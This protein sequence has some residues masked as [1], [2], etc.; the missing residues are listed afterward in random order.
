MNSMTWT[1]RALNGHPAKCDWEVLRYQEF[2]LVIAS[3]RSDN[4]G[5]RYHQLGRTPRGRSE[6][7]A[8]HPAE[9]IGVDRTLPG[10]RRR[11]SPDAGRLGPG[12]VSVA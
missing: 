12:D 3:E 11:I 10:A 7:C 4:T 2:V 8:G 1:Y 9:V 6:P 5:T